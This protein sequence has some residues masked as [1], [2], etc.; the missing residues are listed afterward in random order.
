MKIL[1][2]IG[3]RPEAI[4]MCPLIRELKKR[5]GVCAEICATGQ[6]GRLFDEVA[7]LF[8][9]HPVCNFDLM[10]SV[11]SQEELV[12]G[13]LARLPAVLE[14]EKPSLLLVH[15][16]TSSALAAA[17]CG[18]W[19]KIPVAHIEAGLRTYKPLPFPEEFNRR[20]ISL[21][22]S[23]H[24]APTESARDNLLREGVEP[25]RIF[26]TGNTGLDALKYTVTKTWHS[27]FAAFTEGKKTVLVTAHRRES[28]DIL[29]DMMAGIADVSQIRHD[30]ALLVPAHP[31]P[32]VQETMRKIFADLPN[33]KVIPALD[34]ATFHNLLA[35]SFCVLTDSGGI[36]EEA[37]ALHIPTL[38]LRDETERPE[39]VATG[40]LLPIGRTRE[41]IREGFLNLLCDEALYR[42]MKNAQNPY[43]DGDASKKI[44]DIL[45]SFSSAN[46]QNSSPS[47]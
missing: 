32:V 11:N 45:I 30:I 42:R 27:P 6:H 5:E 17:L 21:V 40:S 37:A 4:K 43:G 33:V 15:G 3:T 23:L 14:S 18:F 41:S 2:V 12:G 35:T 25:E 1:A 44:A 39:G 47:P 38:V 10:S 36:Q 29:Q 22:A 26:V 20:A 9:I 24:F 7:E 13:I 34:V 46:P 28:H 31:N 16:D 19:E 8:D